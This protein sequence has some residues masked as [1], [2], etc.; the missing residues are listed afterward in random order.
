V[1]NFIF[2]TWIKL[3]VTFYRIV[4]LERNVLS[5]DKFL[6]SLLPKWL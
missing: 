3:F 4:C 1:V 6:P 5:S 2:P